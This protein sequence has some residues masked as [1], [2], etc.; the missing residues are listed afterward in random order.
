MPE[1]KRIM[2]DVEKALMEMWVAFEKGSG[3]R[4]HAFSIPVREYLWEILS[5]IDKINE[6]ERAYL[7]DVSQ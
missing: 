7:L 6:L 1:E 3:F 4:D 2:D 5:R